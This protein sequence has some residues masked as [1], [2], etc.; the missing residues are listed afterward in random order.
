MAEAAPH[1]IAACT[2]HHASHVTKRFRTALQQEGVSPTPFDVPMQLGSQ[3]GIASAEMARTILV[4]SHAMT[5]LRASLQELTPGLLGGQ[6][7]GR[8]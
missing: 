3:P 4:T 5:E 7:A 1:D 8:R 2:L 6:H